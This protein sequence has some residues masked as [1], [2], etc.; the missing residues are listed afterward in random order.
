MMCTIT[1]HPDDFYFDHY[2]DFWDFEDDEDY[3]YDHV[4]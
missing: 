2:D 1:S 3:F 4:D